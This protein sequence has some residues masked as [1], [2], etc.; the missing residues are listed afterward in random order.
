MLES[1]L[2]PEASEIWIDDARDALLNKED[3]KASCGG[4]DLLSRLFEPMV[5]MRDRCTGR[6]FLEELAAC[7]G[8]EPERSAMLRAHLVSGRTEYHP[9]RSRGMT[10]PDVTSTQ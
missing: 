6:V 4:K 1:I 2:P 7:Y 8:E 3:P 9:Q 5:S 10:T